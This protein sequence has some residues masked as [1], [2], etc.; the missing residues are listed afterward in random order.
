M[1][2][3][4]VFR[5]EDWIQAGRVAEYLDARGIALAEEMR[6]IRSAAGRARYTR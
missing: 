3:V 4:R 1:K 6:L 5:H 2:P